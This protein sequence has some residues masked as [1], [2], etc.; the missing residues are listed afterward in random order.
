MEDTFA[1]KAN[2]WDSN[3]LRAEMV[4]KFLH[5]VHK[6]AIS[7]KRE[8][9][10]DFG[11]GTG[12][13]GLD[14]IQSTSEVIFIDTSPA[15]LHVLRQK[16]SDANIAHARII[17]GSIE[18]SDEAQ[19][20]DLITSLMSIHH[21]EDIDLILRQMAARLTPDGQLIIGDLM[22]EDGSFHHPE[23]VPHNG[24]S[25]EKLE[26][27]LA[28]AGMKISHFSVFHTMH[29]PSQNGEKKAFDLFV[30]VATKA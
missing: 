12:V 28:E 17:E 22:P 21:V 26:K 8:R 7:E 3:P 14:F 29:K 5:E 9:M 19:K 16:V 23:V 11:C 13:V 24:F 1:A 30:L 2:E 20:A 15:M 25:A 4:K 27:S 10:I 6:Y 18:Q